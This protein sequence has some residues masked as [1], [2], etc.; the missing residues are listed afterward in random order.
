MKNDKWFIGTFIGI[1]VL[2]ILTYP[3]TFILSRKGLVNIAFDNFKKPVYENGMFSSFTN[4]IEKIEVSIENRVNNYFP[5]YH[6]INSFNSNVNNN[7]NK[8]LYKLFGIDY[9]P[10]GS[11]SQ[12]EMI[13]KTDKQFNLLNISDKD[14]LNENMEKQINFLN[15]VSKLDVNTYIYFVN[16]AEFYDFYN[17]N[18]LN[19]MKEYY[20]K[21]KSKLSKNIKTDELKVNN[22]EEY[23]KYFFKTDHHWNMYGA[24]QGYK[25][26]MKL[27]NKESVDGEIFKVDGIKYIGSMGKSSYD[28]SLYDDLYDIKVNLKNH[29]VYVNDSEDIQNYKE[30]KIK[31]TNNIYYDH[32]V[33]YFNGMYGKV[34]YDFNQEDK[35]NLLIIGDSFTWQID[36]LIASSYNK[37]YIINLRYDEYENGKLDLKKFIKDN[38]ISDV[39]FLYETNA[40]MFDQYNYDF[41]NKIER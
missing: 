18:H 41:I 36:N 37:T 6:S 3:I 1:I 21:F 9:Y 13:F 38:N 25:D 24:Y 39:L 15:D 31:D 12:N 10:V 16:R 28:S 22:K 17:I 40:L 20:L 33:A 19:N 2:I 32:Y 34:E 4:L 27:M 14:I 26:I 23:L 30:H 35:A 5:L 11:D 7:L 8:G 29:A